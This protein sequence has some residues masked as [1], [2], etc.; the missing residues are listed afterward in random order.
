LDYQQA[1][2]FK[3]LNFMRKPSETVRRTPKQFRLRVMSQSRLQHKI[4]LWLVKASV[5]SNPRVVGSI[6]TRPTNQCKK[7][8]YY[9]YAFFFFIYFGF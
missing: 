9:K 3:V 7:R 8:I 1:T 4:I 6:P 2:L 5:V